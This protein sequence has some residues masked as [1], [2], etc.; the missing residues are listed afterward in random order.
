[1]RIWNAIPPEKPDNL[2]AYLNTVIK[3]LAYNKHEMQNA[4]KHGSNQ[5][6]LALDE[7]SE[8][9]DE[10]QVAAPE[11]ETSVP[12]EENADPDAQVEETIVTPTATDVTTFEATTETS[13]TS[14][15]QAEQPPTE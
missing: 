11:N 15:E 13:T 6:A 12:D 5:H 1:M 3:R 14:A 2:S 9:T 10:T 4:A 7:L 8:V